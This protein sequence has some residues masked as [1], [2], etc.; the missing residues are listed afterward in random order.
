[1]LH[2]IVLNGRKLTY[3]LT[4]KQVKNINLRLHTDCS[5]HVS[6]PPRTAVASIERFMQENAD[7]ILDVMEKVGKREALRQQKELFEDGGTVF[8]LGEPYRLR[9]LEGMRNE[10]RL[11]SGE[12]LL[13][14]KDPS[15]PILRKKTVEKWLSVR[16]KEQ[17]TELCHSIYPYYQ[18]RGIPFPSLRFRFM[19]SRWGSCNASKGILTFNNRLAEKPVECIAYVVAHEFT[20]FLHADHSKRFYGELE[21]MMPDWKIRRKLL[22]E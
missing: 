2:E 11:G 16:C 9:V 1:M 20:H 12:L 18:A 6:A 4:R 7:R 22:N 15:D 19:K 17:I 10:V 3:E 8:Y 14:V 5:I 13:T 21:K